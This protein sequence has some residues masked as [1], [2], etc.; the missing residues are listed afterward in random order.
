MY[1]WIT[2]NWFDPLKEQI[3][4][5]SFNF[6]SK[7]VHVLNR[8]LSFIVNKTN[9]FFEFS[10][11]WSL[12][13]LTVYNIAQTTLRPSCLLCSVYYRWRHRPPGTASASVRD[14]KIGA[15]L[16]VSHI[17]QW[18]RWMLQPWGDK[19]FNFLIQMSSIKCWLL[20]VLRINVDLA[21]FQ[22]Y[23]DLEAGDNQSLKI[24]VAKPGIEPRSSCSA[25]QELNHSATAA[26]FFN[27]K[28]KGF[29]NIKLK[30]NGIVCVKCD[31]AIYVGET[32]RTLKE[33]ISEHMQDIKNSADK[34]INCH[35]QNHDE[36]D[37]VY[38]VLQRL[39]NE[40]SKALA[41]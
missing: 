23:L 12:S 37:I 25:S 4:L 26:P 10:T 39:G 31:R 41:F 14:V 1:I 28:A 11:S 32:E 27:K 30:N 35:F 19:V 38:A 2:M 36:K 13:R 40:N 29:R 6:V 5:L 8:P 22:P 21:I 20:V 15:L 16:K 7:N 33:Q 9:S 24:Q 34:P 17:H 18:F 3:S